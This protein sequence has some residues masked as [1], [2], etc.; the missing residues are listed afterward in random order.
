MTEKS[1]RL[2]DDDPAAPFRRLAKHA[3]GQ[4]DEDWARVNRRLAQIFGER[5]ND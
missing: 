5:V 2:Q 4:G 3:E 1:E